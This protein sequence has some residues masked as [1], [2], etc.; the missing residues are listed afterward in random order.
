[1]RIVQWLFR[2]ATQSL[3]SGNLL[4]TR[5]GA[6]KAN[7]RILMNGMP[8]LRK[9]L[10]KGKTELFLNFYFKLYVSLAFCPLEIHFALCTW[11]EISLKY[12][13]QFHFKLYFLG[14]FV[15][16][17]PFSSRMPAAKWAFYFI[18]CIECPCTAIQCQ[19]L[20]LHKGAIKSWRFFVFLFQKMHKIVERERQSL[21]ST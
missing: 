15:K 11:G 9:D 18:S 4:K 10:S 13:Y 7:F 12:Q 19:V 21:S 20:F 5:F 14:F 6:S 1:M 8:W 2:F 3:S 17:W 16:Q